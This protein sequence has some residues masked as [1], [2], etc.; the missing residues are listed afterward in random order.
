MNKF[1]ELF[2]GFFPETP[3]LKIDPEDRAQRL[4]IL[5]KHDPDHCFPPFEVVVADDLK[6]EDKYNNC[7]LTAVTNEKPQLLYAF[8][9]RVDLMASDEELKERFIDT[10]R[11]VRAGYSVPDLF[12]GKG[13]NNALRSALKSLGALRLR[14]TMEDAAVISHT[15]KI[16]SCGLY[17]NK[18]GLSRAERQA[19]MIIDS[20]T[21]LSFEDRMEC[22]ERSP[23]SNEVRQLLILLALGR[24]RATQHLVSVFP[25]AVVLKRGRHTRLAFQLAFKRLKEKAPPTPSKK[26]RARSA[27]IGGK[28]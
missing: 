5:K 27:K 13:A 3:W 6:E 9:I 24:T 1:R 4:A 23:A 17:A 19:R 22:I 25:D 18:S 21:P 14:K 20:W 28:T 15:R 12:E 26:G 10:V 11:K 2:R 8:P 7:V 16:L